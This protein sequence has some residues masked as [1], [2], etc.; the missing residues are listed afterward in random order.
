MYSE[1]ES[2]Y[3]RSSGVIEVMDVLTLSTYKNG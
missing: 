3:P 1:M 2:V